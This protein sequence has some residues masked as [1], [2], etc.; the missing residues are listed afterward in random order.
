MRIT[1]SP[2][3]AAA[4]MLTACLGL[5]VSTPVDVDAQVTYDRVVVFG[6][7]LSDS[8]NAFALIGTAST[9]PDF[10]LDVFLI[11]SAPYARGGHHLSNGATWIEQL[12]RSSGLAA[13]ARPAFLGNNSGATNYAVAGARARDYGDTLNLSQ[14]VAAFLQDVGGV[15]PSNAL[16]VIE[17]GANDLRDALTAIAQ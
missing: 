6:T 7:S 12:A 14:Q 15:A 11:P 4:W 16:Y 2:A 17:M 8:G 10:S 1:I 13:S 5:V 3:N 9:P